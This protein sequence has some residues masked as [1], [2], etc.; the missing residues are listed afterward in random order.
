[1]FN[2][3]ETQ[4]PIFTPRLVLD[5]LSPSRLVTLFDEPENDIIYRDRDYTNPYHDLIDNPGPLK[6]RVPQVKKDVALNKWFLRWIV[7]ASAKEIIG[8]ISFHGPPNGNGMIEIGLGVQPDFQCRGYAKEALAGMWSWVIEQ[9]DVEVLRY[10]VS[11]TNLASMKIIHG[12]DFAHVGVQMDKE[13][14][15]EE[16]FEMSAAEFQ[17]RHATSWRAPSS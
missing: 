13:D 11:A 12:F 14:G 4:P 1:M 3:D 5:H 6:W 16:I 7:L 9:P 2:D 15:L 17:R 10:T 8:S